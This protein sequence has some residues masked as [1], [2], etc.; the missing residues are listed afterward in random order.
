MATF[1]RLTD[2]VNNTLDLEEAKVFFHVFSEK[3]VQEYIIF[4]NTNIQLHNYGIDA[5]GTTLDSIGGSY[6]PYT[7]RQK[8][9]KGD[10]YKH[11]TLKDTGEFY[12]S[13]SVDVFRDEFVIDAYYI[14]EGTD[15]R[16]RWG[17]DLAGLTPLS[18]E[19]LKGFI[20]PKVREIV[21]NWILK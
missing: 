12:K 2:F 20:L 19:K 14:K 17:D 9:R 16:D 7:I 8:K 21:L 10:E 5:T 11:V 6:A 1:G 18:V 4:L 3:D 13:F 15:L